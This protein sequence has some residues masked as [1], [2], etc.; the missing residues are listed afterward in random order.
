MQRQIQEPQDAARIANEATATAAAATAAA[1][2]AEAE[3]VQAA[4]VADKAAKAVQAAAD[5]QAVADGV[6]ANNKPK[7][8]VPPTTH[9]VGAAV[10]QTAGSDDEEDALL[11]NSDQTIEPKPRKPIQVNTP[12]REGMEVENAEGENPRKRARDEVNEDKPASLD[13]VRKMLKLGGDAAANSAAS[14]STKA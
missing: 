13:A 8:K 6:R 5:A 12:Q 3:K 14:S 1:A 10:G 7:E 11:A 9:E 2:A 4:A